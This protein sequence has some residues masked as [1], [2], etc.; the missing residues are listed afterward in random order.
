MTAIKDARR[1]LYCTPFDVW[2]LSRL[3]ARQDLTKDAADGLALNDPYEAEVAS[4][5]EIESHILQADGE[6]RI[7]LASLYA[8]SDFLLT[9]PIAGMPMASLGN[10]TKE[11]VAR[12]YAVLA[13]TS[14]ITELWAIEFDQ[15][16]PN[17]F[18]V[19]GTFS[20]SQGNGS[21]GATFTSTN[22]DLV[23]ES[24]FWWLLDDEVKFQKNDKFYVTTYDVKPEIMNISAKLASASLLRSVLSQA[25]QEDAA[26]IRNLEKAARDMLKK[27]L[28]G[29]M[30][31]TAYPAELEPD[32]YAYHIDSTG[33]LLSDRSKISGD[34]PKNAGMST[35]DS[36]DGDFC[37]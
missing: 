4:I 12:L 10:E 2:T 30:R 22:T 28:D 8:E 5:P 23:I 3:V 20:G 34:E 31:L 33:L 9:A 19:R 14:A 11:N 32:A 1:K 16:A 21:T 17:T 15:T 6:I 18:S 35:T 25:S 37:R 24:G 26:F 36:F 13:G 7:T 27:L 29:T